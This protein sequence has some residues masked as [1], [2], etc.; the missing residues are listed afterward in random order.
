MFLPGRQRSRAG[1]ARQA[2]MME[3]VD[4]VVDDLRRRNRDLLSAV[5]L[6]SRL[7]TRSSGG[8]TRARTRHQRLNT[9][10]VQHVQTRPPPRLAASRTNV[11]PSSSF[12]RIHASRNC[13]AVW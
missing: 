10:R 13:C 2:L 11:L 6:G 12:D 3:R 9:A 8:R 5:G 1:A 4:P 7:L